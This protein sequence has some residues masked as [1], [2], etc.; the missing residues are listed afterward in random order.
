[1]PKFQVT[2]DR[3]YEI[4]AQDEI[5][6]MDQAELWGTLIDGDVFIQEVDA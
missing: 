4:V 1:M 6:A 5:E 3:T 2:F